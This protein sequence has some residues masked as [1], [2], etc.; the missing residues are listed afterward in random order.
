DYVAEVWID[1]HRCGAHEGGYTPFSF[2]ITDRVQGGGT[3]EIALRA[4]DDPH[5]LAKPRGKQDWQLDPHSIWYPRTSG[6]WQSVWFERVPA[7]YIS[8]LRWT[9]NLER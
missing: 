5:D 8:K 9:P 4:E 2:D 7:S 6:I 3:H 1:G